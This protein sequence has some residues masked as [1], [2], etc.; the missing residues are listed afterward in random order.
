MLRQGV[1]DNSPKA[2]LIMGFELA[3]E[4]EVVGEG[5]TGFRV[6]D[7]VSA[8]TD[9]KAWSELVNVPIK[10]VYKLPAKIS[11]QDAVGI[12]LNYVVAY[13]LLFDV[14]NLRSGQTVLAHSIGG[15][16]VR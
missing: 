3:G 15:G 10:Y 8:L 7:R 1:I 6:G 13:A 16:V 14:G 5:V 11:F 9:S 4:I 2:P 12:T